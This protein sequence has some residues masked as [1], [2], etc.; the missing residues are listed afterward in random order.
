MGTALPGAESC[1]INITTGMDEREEK[2]VKLYAKSCPEC[3]FM[4]LKGQC[5]CFLT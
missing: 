2:A 4:A 5:T 1:Y 3:S